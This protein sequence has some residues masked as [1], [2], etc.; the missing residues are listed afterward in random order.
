MTKV[1]L[2]ENKFG[3]F[4]ITLEEEVEFTCFG[5]PSKT[6]LFIRCVPA[7]YILEF[8]SFRDWLRE[9]YTVEKK[10]GTI[11]SVGHE[12]HEYLWGYLKPYRLEVTNSCG[13][14]PRHGPASAKF[15]YIGKVDWYD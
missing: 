9:N 1:E 5:G 4:L 6:K 12:I 2:L 11:E 8:M 7:N 3:S 15:G 13:M 10:N 14:V